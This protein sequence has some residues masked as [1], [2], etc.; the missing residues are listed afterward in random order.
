MSPA[1]DDKAAIVSQV[2]AAALLSYQL[3][4]LYP[5]PP[6]AHRLQPC[7][8]RPYGQVQSCSFDGRVNGR[9]SVYRMIRL[10]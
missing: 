6:R 9:Y 3:A 7:N 5:R 4:S 10:L 1:P 8:E 2:D